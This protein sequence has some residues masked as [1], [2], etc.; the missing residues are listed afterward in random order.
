VIATPAATAV[1]HTAPGWHV[2]ESYGCGAAGGEPSVNGP[3]RLKFVKPAPA[4]AQLSPFMSAKLLVAP[5]VENSAFST[6]CVMMS[7]SGSKVDPRGHW[8]CGVLCE[9][10]QVVDSE[11]TASR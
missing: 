1:E 4:T 11:G 10:C 7:S 6:S 9:S 8:P 3:V 5:A 2:L